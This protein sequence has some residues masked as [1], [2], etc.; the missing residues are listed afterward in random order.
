MVNNVA[1]SARVASINK[2][3]PDPITPIPTSE[4]TNAGLENKG[5][6]TPPS[7]QDTSTGG[8]L[9]QEDLISRFQPQNLFR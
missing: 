4:I 5:L 9:T 6:M 1:T 8:L 3:T 7:P 2:R